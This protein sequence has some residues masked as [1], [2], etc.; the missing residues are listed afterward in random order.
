MHHCKS[1]GAGRGENESHTPALLQLIADTLKGIT[2][3]RKSKVLVSC[4]V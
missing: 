1:A 2:A 3:T 4:I